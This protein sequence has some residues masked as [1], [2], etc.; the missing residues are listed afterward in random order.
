[1]G[2]ENV[3]EEG[4]LRKRP[5]EHEEQKGDLHSGQA[6]AKQ[7]Q[8]PR[9]GEKQ[10]S[11]EED[12][13]LDNQ[14]DAN[15]EDHHHCDEERV[16]GEEEPLY[17]GIALT[18]EAQERGRKCKET[19]GENRENQGNKKDPFVDKKEWRNEFVSKKGQL[20]KRKSTTHNSSVSNMKKF[21]NVFTKLDQNVNIA[22]SSFLKCYH[23]CFFILNLRLYENDMFRRIV[24]KVAQRIVLREDNYVKRIYSVHK[25]YIEKE[26]R[27]R[28][29]C[30]GIA[31]VEQNDYIKK[32]ICKE[33]KENS[34][35]SLY[36]KAKQRDENFS[37]SIDYLHS[38]F[39]TRLC[40]LSLD[41][42]LQN[43]II[44]FLNRCMEFIKEYYQ[45]QDPRFV[46]INKMMNVYSCVFSLFYLRLNSFSEFHTNKLSKILGIEKNVFSY[47]DQATWHML[48]VFNFVNFR[49]GCSYRF[50]NT[51]FT[52]FHVL[53]NVLVKIDAHVEMDRKRIGRGRCKGGTQI[54]S[55]RNTHANVTRLPNYEQVQKIIERE[56]RKKVRSK[57]VLQSVGGVRFGKGIIYKIV[58]E[59]KK[60]VTVSGK[61][62]IKNSILENIIGKR[63]NRYFVNPLGE[64]V[65]MNK[66]ERRMGEM[67]DAKRMEGVGSV[68]SGTFSNPLSSPF[69][70]AEKGLRGGYS[71]DPLSAIHTKSQVET[72][73]AA[74]RCAASKSK[75][76]VM[77]KGGEFQM[78]QFKYGSRNQ[79]ILQSYGKLKK[80]KKKLKRKINNVC[81]FKYIAVINKSQNK[82]YTTL[83]RT[84]AHILFI[85]ISILHIENYNIL[86]LRKNHD[87][88]LNND[89]YNTYYLFLH[90]S[91]SIILLLSS[92]LKTYLH[93][94][95]SVRLDKEE[96]T[97]PKLGQT[98][99]L[100]GIAKRGKS[101][102]SVR[103]EDGMAIEMASEE[104][105]YSSRQ[106]HLSQD[107]S[108]SSKRSSRRSSA[109]MSNHT[110]DDNDG[111]FR[112][113]QKEE[114]NTRGYQIYLQ[115][116]LNFSSINVLLMSKKKHNK[117]NK[118][119]KNK[120]IFIFCNL[121]ENLLQNSMFYVDLF[122][123]C[124]NRDVLEMNDVL[125]KLTKLCKENNIMN[126]FMQIKKELIYHSLFKYILQEEYISHFNM[127][128]NELYNMN[129]CS[130]NLF[131]FSL[132][133]LLTIFNT[134]ISIHLERSLHNIHYFYHDNLYYELI[135]NN[136]KRTVRYIRESSKSSFNCIFACVLYYLSRW[137]KGGGKMLKGKN[138]EEKNIFLRRNTSNQRFASSYNM[139][140]V[141]GSLF[142]NLFSKEECTNDA[143]LTGSVNNCW[144]DKEDSHPKCYNHPGEASY[145][146]FKTHEGITPGNDKQVEKEV[147]KEVEKQAEK[148]DE[149]EVEKEVEKEDEKEVEKEVE[150]EDEKEVEKV[151][152]KQDEKQAEKQDEK[153]AEE[154]AEKQAEK[155]AEKQ[156]THLK[157][158]QRN[159][160]KI[161]SK[162]VYDMINPYVDIKHIKVHNKIYRNNHTINSLI[163]ICFSFLFNNF[164]F[165]KPVYPFDI[166]S[167][168]KSENESCGK[169]IR[170]TN[171]TLDIFSMKMS[172][173]K[174]V[175]LFLSL[176]IHK[177]MQS[178]CLDVKKLVDY[179]TYMNQFFWVSNR[180]SVSVSF[181]SSDYAYLNYASRNVY[182]T[183]NDY[184][185]L[186]FLINFKRS[187]SEGKEFMM[188]FVK[189]F[190]RMISLDDETSADYT[191]PLTYNVYLD[192]LKD[193][194]LNDDYYYV[195]FYEYIKNVYL[196]D[197]EGGFQIE[198]FDCYIKEL[199]EINP[200]KIKEEMKRKFDEYVQ[201]NYLLLT[202]RRSRRRRSERG[203]RRKGR[204]RRKTTP[205]DDYTHQ[206]GKGTGDVQK[207]TI[208]GEEKIKI[209]L[210]NNPYHFKNVYRAY[211]NRLF[212]LVNK[213]SIDY[214]ELIKV[215][216]KK[217]YNHFSNM[218]YSSFIHI[219]SEVKYDYN[220]QY[221]FNIAKIM[222]KLNIGLKASFY[223]NKNVIL[224]YYT[225]QQYFHLYK[226]L[227]DK[228]F[229]EFVL[230]E[231]ILLNITSRF[232][233]NFLYNSNLYRIYCFLKFLYIRNVL[234]HTDILLNFLLY[235]YY[236]Y[237]H[238]H[239]RGK[240]EFSHHFIDLFLSIHEESYNNSLLVTE[241]K[242][243]ESCVE[244]SLLGRGNLLAKNPL[245]GE[246]PFVA[247]AK[248]GQY[249]DEI[250]R[251]GA[252]CDG[253]NNEII[254]A[255]EMYNDDNHELKGGNQTQSAYQ[256]IN[257]YHLVLSNSQ[258]RFIH[259]LFFKILT[260]CVKSKINILNAKNLFNNLNFFISSYVKYS[261]FYTFE[262]KNKPFMDALRHKYSFYNFQAVKKN[263]TFY[264]KNVYL[265]RDLFNSDILSF[266]NIECAVERPHSRE[267]LSKKNKK[268]MRT[269]VHPNRL[270]TNLVP[271]K[272]WSM[273]MKENTFQS[274]YKG[275]ADWS[276]GMTK[277][278]IEKGQSVTKRRMCMVL[279]G[280]V[281]TK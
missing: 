164:L 131:Y 270:T 245:V 226:F 205:C 92:V 251:E 208:Q 60:K 95:P 123:N 59:V 268:D 249:G 67:C 20:K 127:D 99:G 274:R 16:P 177:Y 11:S 214:L 125:S 82:I 247:S 269:L 143:M 199:N 89:I 224:Y 156:T 119:K 174:A 169:K 202:V 14:G 170:T 236:K 252:K 105:G 41:F 232:V 263:L 129:K 225:F 178:I 57:G 100:I 173:I 39:D 256:E 211:K 227:E 198:N 209:V 76:V 115:T 51:I 183:F 1:M 36:K 114:E 255:D 63:M 118:M 278:P 276:I 5:Y 153:Q 212:N 184:N 93:F 193:L 74:D 75:I 241:L 238:Y 180:R 237:F 230:P 196:E 166:V 130:L 26:G 86:H 200:Y 279:K 80:I 277:L 85:L 215:L 69:C 107:G 62:K 24:W 117:R 50:L 28:V 88:F 265:K 264:L 145:G 4:L 262:E 150:K 72:I 158:Q 43:I 112:M 149:K 116:L 194:F 106:H 222:D 136:V 78:S 242:A 267:G 250:D 6:N 221:N 66:L 168:E 31:D 244:N 91:S 44:E 35:L 122:N 167:K 188:S 191:D 189:V 248:E 253:T 70:G 185:V 104:G 29:A 81:Y 155:R 55:A 53:V 97:G 210:N 272:I 3:V 219:L 121:M 52:S 157:A 68:L 187:K 146:I 162:I 280:A 257:N 87:F 229:S 220:K 217:Q 101:V 172:D 98:N 103:D 147:E 2:E 181:P 47:D 192:Y 197:N 30:H 48:N 128:K 240:D 34:I 213:K 190:E 137:K 96:F 151:V 141:K 133:I 163:N 45:E 152:E 260:N 160:R 46:I 38:L 165:L 201:K 259:L 132:N 25:N 42:E 175:E 111:K 33:L 79:R 15:E 8:L 113:G 261:L 120:Y 254:E 19:L 258:N 243:K 234:K 84:Y 148:Q 21:K 83:S 235:V 223:N 71:S 108:A 271:P 161:I 40:M 246:I 94:N 135:L 17:E 58:N 109:S 37:Q 18:E 228:Y 9:E 139:E 186:Q 134:D 10:R 275:A 154:Q 77:A 64:E 140:E 110:S 142:F 216:N 12:G 195:C 266:L 54:S 233:N 218:F 102:P 159:E 27:S 273:F 13:I 182:Y 90:I 206:D 176:Y 61:L 22:F 203:K 281:K 179:N 73:A 32:C 126:D 231:Y 144:K 56:K 207:L 171:Y 204:K 23:K 49:Y 124:K 65:G 138:S 239:Y 7:G